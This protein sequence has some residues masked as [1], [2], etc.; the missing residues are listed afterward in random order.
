MEK[1]KYE[2]GKEIKTVR[3]LLNVSTQAGNA[4]YATLFAY[5][6]R[7]GL[8]G[9]IIITLKPHWT[10]E[11]VQR[12]LDIYAKDGITLYERVAIPVQHVLPQ[13]MEYALEQFAMEYDHLKEF[14]DLETENWE[15]LFAKFKNDMDNYSGGKKND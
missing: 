13:C 8:Y 1:Y 11:D 14:G 2:V 6:P 3:D 5:N 10:T 4:R 12:E 9:T 15:K 7:L